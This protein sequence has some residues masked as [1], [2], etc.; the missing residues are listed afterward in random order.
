MAE[1]PKVLIP[2]TTPAFISLYA[3]TPAVNRQLDFCRY[4][5]RA[6]HRL[7]QAFFQDMAS[8]GVLSQPKGSS[9]AEGHK[10]SSNPQQRQQQFSGVPE[11]NADWV[12]DEEEEDIGDFGSSGESTRGAPS[13]GRPQKRSLENERG[14]SMQGG[15]GVGGRVFGG[16]GGGGREDRLTLIL[17]EG[18]HPEPPPPGD[19]TL[20]TVLQ[21][22]PEMRR[23]EA[24]GSW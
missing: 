2:F 23:M 17:D 9:F 12:D 3:Q 11:T 21:E 20:K 8:L 15:S 7:N 6:D 10:Q 24:E 19:E 16:V 14:R 4:L 18:T 1:G 5:L 22:M 13:S